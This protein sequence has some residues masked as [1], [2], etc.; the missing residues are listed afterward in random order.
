MG[1]CRVEGDQ[2]EKKQ[3]NFNSVIGKI[4]LKEKKREI[5]DHILLLEQWCSL[6][7]KVCEIRG[8]LKM[9]LSGEH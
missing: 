2:G 8:K 3:N 4:Y 1:R 9:F 5:T 6:K 7:K